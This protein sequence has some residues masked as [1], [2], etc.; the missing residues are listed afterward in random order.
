MLKLQHNQ[1]GEIMAKVKMIE[2][3]LSLGTIAYS[4]WTVSK[5]SYDMATKF[6][7]ANPKRKVCRIG[8]GQKNEIVVVF[9]K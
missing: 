7:I 1:T 3:N 9:T 2:T 4:G 6:F 5:S 8:I